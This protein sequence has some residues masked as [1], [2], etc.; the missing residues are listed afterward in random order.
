MS[1]DLHTHSTMSDGTQTPEEI[2]AEAAHKGLA[3]ISITDHDTAAGV[4]PALEAA[5]GTGVLVIP[6]VEI[7]TEH[8]KA[9]VHILGYYFDLDD[10]ALAEVFSYV[11]EAREDRAEVMAGKLRAL[12]VAITAE[13]I[14]SESDGETLGRPHVAA[15]LVRK[16]H[17][18]HLQEAFDRYIGSGRPAY[19]PRYKLS[20]FEAVAAILAAGGCPVLAHPGL[21]VGDRIIHQLAERGLVGLEAWHSQHTPSNTRRALRLAEELGLL[22]TGGTD[23]HGPGGSHPVEVGAIDVPDSCAQA[24]LA[25]AREHNA[26]VPS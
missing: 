11:Q 13:E 4:R 1:V 2:I 10:P 14:H 16:G 24:L 12:G 21:G 22:V 23:S 8:D 7:S 17:V 5:R 3:A 15:A 18:G 20:P 6:G 9:E 19:V 25:W 26:P